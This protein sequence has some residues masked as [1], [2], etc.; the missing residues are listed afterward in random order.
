MA[1]VLVQGGV[2]AVP[3]GYFSD[4]GGFAM[5][6]VE[7]KHQAGLLSIKNQNWE[8]HLCSILL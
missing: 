4:W 5:R 2:A 3:E 7:S 1:C 8:W 6:S